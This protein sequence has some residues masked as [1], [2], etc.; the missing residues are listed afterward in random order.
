MS[1]NEYRRVVTFPNGYGASIVSHGNSYGG[2]EGLFE[3]AVVKDDKLCYD[4]PVA[5]NVEGWLDFR[6]VAE[7]LEQIENLPAK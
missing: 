3:L 2:K 7:L 5:S 4:T 1:E 6:Q